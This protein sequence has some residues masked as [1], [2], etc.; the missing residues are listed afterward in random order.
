MSALTVYYYEEQ[1][2]GQK[3]IAPTRKSC[4]APFHP[5]AQVI[6]Q[7]TRQLG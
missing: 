1:C 5:F 7:D 3:P 6:P 2:H 4:H